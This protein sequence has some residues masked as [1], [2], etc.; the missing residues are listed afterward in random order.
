MTQAEMEALRDSKLASAQPIT[1]LIH[2]SW[3]Q[4]IINQLYNS[5]NRGDY[6][7]TTTFPQ[8]GG[9]YTG[10]LPLRGDRWRIIT[11]PMVVGGN[12]YGVDTIIEAA[13]NGAGAT[14]LTDWIKYAVQP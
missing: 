6:V 4:D 13:V 8:T 3:G 1:A 5:D 12:V 7:G 2:R 14:T 10:G 9:R 11:T